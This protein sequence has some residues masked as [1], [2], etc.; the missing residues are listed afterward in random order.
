MT[1][2]SHMAAVK[3]AK[4]R[5]LE[6]VQQLSDRIGGGIIIPDDLG[7]ISESLDSILVSATAARTALIAAAAPTPALAQPTSVENRECSAERCLLD[8]QIALLETARTAI[9]EHL[10]RSP[11]PTSIK[12]TLRLIRVS[13]TP[14]SIKLLQAEIATE[15]LKELPEEVPPTHYSRCSIV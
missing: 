12:D 9:R 10:D 11:S 13:F 8:R 1:F 14:E 15:L 5:M 2:S 7:Y 4:Q 6:Q 3:L